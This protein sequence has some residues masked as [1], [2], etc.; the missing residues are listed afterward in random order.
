MRIKER[1]FQN[2]TKKAVRVKERSHPMLPEEA[3]KCCIVGVRACTIFPK[4]SSNRNFMASSV[5]FGALFVRSYSGPKQLTR[6]LLLAPTK[7]KEIAFF[8][9]MSDK[10][11]ASKRSKAV[12]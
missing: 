1:E 7:R 10:W 5:K 6:A 4:L 11:T 9:F 3:S 8:R 12:L 2:I